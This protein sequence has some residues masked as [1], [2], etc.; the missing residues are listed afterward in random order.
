M[1]LNLWS[2][3][4]IKVDNF[5]LFSLRRFNQEGED[6]HAARQK[7]KTLL[8]LILRDYVT[9]RQRQVVLCYYLDGM[10]VKEI[11]RMLGVSPP[12]VS[13]TLARA[14]GKMQQVAKGLMDSGILN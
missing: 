11:A 6:N 7:Y 1:P 12:S 13:R 5:D 9:E 4:Q 8:S 3:K 14:R 10:K 2:K